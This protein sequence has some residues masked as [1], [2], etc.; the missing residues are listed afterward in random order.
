MSDKTTAFDDHAFYRSR[1]GWILGVCR[2][3]AESRD[4]PVFWVRVIAVVLLFVTGIWPAVLVYLAA[5][6][7]MSPEPVLSLRDDDDLEFYHSYS[8]S[9]KMALARLKRTYDNLD[10]RIQRMETT[11]TGREY[12]WDRRFR[13]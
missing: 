9:R 4:V 11:V 1:R 7:L 13:E 10:H 8:H 12:D 2:G 6:L 5:A 3:I